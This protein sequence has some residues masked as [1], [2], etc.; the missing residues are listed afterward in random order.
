MDAGAGLT[1][2]FVMAGM[3]SDAAGLARKAM[4]SASFSASPGLR[5]RS[6]GMMNSH[7]ICKCNTIKVSSEDLA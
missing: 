2:T 4:F 3:I 5:A 6:E 1:L 7:H